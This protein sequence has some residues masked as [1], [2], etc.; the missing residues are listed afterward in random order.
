MEPGSSQESINKTCQVSVFDRT[1]SSSS[2]EARTPHR[3]SP[4]PLAHETIW[5]TDAR[6]PSL[7]SPASIYSAREPRVVG[8]SPYQGFYDDPGYDSDRENLR[9]VS[10]AMRKNLSEATEVPRTA[11]PR[12]EKPLIA[13]DSHDDAWQVVQSRRKPKKTSISRDLGS[14]RPTPARVT[15]AEA[16]KSAVGSITARRTE[17]EPRQ[18]DARNALREV[19]SKS[20]PPSRQGALNSSSFWQSRNP[21]RE[22]ANLTWAR[23]AA[24]QSHHP[25]VQPI[26]P[27]AGLIN[28]PPGADSVNEPIR[29]RQG[30]AHSSPLVS[31]FVPEGEAYYSPHNSSYLPTPRS[32]VDVKVQQTPPRYINNEKFYP[33]PPNLGPNTAPLP[34]ETIR[35]SEN[36]SLSSKRRLPSDFHSPQ[37]HSPPSRPSSQSPHG[38]PSQ[39]IYYQPRSVLPAGYYSQP[40]SRDVS[41]QSHASAPETEPMRYPRSFSP[42]PPSLAYPH[43]PSSPR[44]RF[45]DGRPLRKSPRSDYAV[46]MSED[47]VPSPSELNYSLSGTGGWATPAFQVSPQFK[48]SNP[49]SGAMSRSSSGPGVRLEGGEGLGIL[50]FGEHVQFGALPPVNV[51][52]AK[53]RTSEWESNPERSRE[54]GRRGLTRA[55]E[56]S[57]Q[58]TAHRAHRVERPYPEVNL[59]P[60]SSTPAGME[61]VD[62]NGDRWGSK[63]SFDEVSI[64]LKRASIWADAVFKRMIKVGFS[65]WFR[66]ALEDK[67][68]EKNVIVDAAAECW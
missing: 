4:L 51:I 42:Q 32:G 53:R 37:Y 23:R 48:T 27:T 6:K 60:T 26:P 38:T 22:S 30:N 58:N 13:T 39:P 1:T 31:E 44:D 63:G 14:F 18:S 33:P 8:H 52:D 62:D 16:R 2:N 34:F 47:E 28:P 43:S 10:H 29:G 66:W 40:M 65:V 24:G 35:A 67:S 11:R 17:S 54:R 64:R 9:Y 5:G 25:R 68:F 49:D 45:A 57:G 41:Y 21:L 59:I 50:P 15:Q 36:L 3:P 61:G 7:E 56:G 20:P 46:Q 12:S 55:E 19:H